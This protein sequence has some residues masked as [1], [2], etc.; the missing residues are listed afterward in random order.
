[1]K[2]L[3]ILSENITTPPTILVEE[4]VKKPPQVR[5]GDNKKHSNKVWAYAKGEFDED[6]TTS[7][8]DL[9]NAIYTTLTNNT[10]H[11]E[12]WMKDPNIDVSLQATQ[13]KS[14]ASNHYCK[15]GTPPDG[16]CIVKP[17]KPNV[18]KNPITP[19]PTGQE[20]G[21]DA[22]RNKAL[23]IKRGI[24][25]W[26]AFK[27]ASIEKNIKIVKDPTIDETA[28]MIY[29]TGGKIDKERIE[30]KYPNP[31]QFVWLQLSL[32][33]TKKPKKQ[34]AVS[35]EQIQSRNCVTGMKVSVVYYADKR[36]GCDRAVQGSCHVCNDA[37]FKVYLN[38]T[39]IGTANL[40]NLQKETQ[41][42]QTGSGSGGSRK[43]TFLVS[44][45]RARE[46]T[47][48]KV[49]KKG[50]QIPAGSVVLAIK[51]INQ[52]SEGVHADVPWIILTTGQGKVIYNQLARGK[53]TWGRGNIDIHNLIGPFNPCKKIT[54]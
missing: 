51:G 37:K 45:E 44:E 5:V 53:E 18:S 26:K 17:D 1:M 41:E 43:S 54:T 10:T 35:K 15:K 36:S 21:G 32:E 46:I 12:K 2:L 38:E 14:G 39:F 4:V 13:F 16:N 25:F 24:N 20:Y 49:D 8:Q 11:F 33:A 50:N 47:Q 28:G 19:L 31:G 9:I 6:N 30:K 22:Q 3:N 7:T 48:S 42:G 27:K 29:D 23:A 52:T 40:N 34:E